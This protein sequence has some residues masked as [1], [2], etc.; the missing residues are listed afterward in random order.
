MI[1]IPARC[2]AMLAIVAGLAGPAMADEVINFG[3][4]PSTQPILVAHGAGYL[5]P[6]EEKFK[7]KIVFGHSPTARRKIRR[8]AAGAIQIASAGMGPAI[9]AA[10]RLPAKLIAI[11]ILDQ[12][13]ILVPKGSK[14]TDRRAAQR[15][16]DRLSRAKARSNIRC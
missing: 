3:V 9:V 11:D 7:V 12:T 16:Q 4:Q 6:I 5:K 1:R 15:R 13:A 10:A 2:V 8:S 14:I